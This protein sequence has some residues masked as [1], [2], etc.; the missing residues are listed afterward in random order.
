MV[1]LPLIASFEVNR[2]KKTK[3]TKINKVVSCYYF[4]YKIGS[5]K[6]LK[7]KDTVQ[8]MTKIFFA[9]TKLFICFFRMIVILFLP[10]GTQLLR[11]ACSFTVVIHF[12]CCFKGYFF[13]TFTFF[14]Q[15]KSLTVDL[16]TS[17]DVCRCSDP[18][19]Y[20]VHCVSRNLFWYYAVNLNFR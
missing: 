6:L 10:F 7:G 2:G 1:N 8:R 15:I 19:Y 12:F 3:P 9:T 16:S 13:W 4:K 17:I 11:L 5:L 18:M 14:F 20:R